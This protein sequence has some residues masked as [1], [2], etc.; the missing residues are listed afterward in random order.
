MCVYGGRTMN[1][2]IM[3]IQQVAEYLQVCDKTIRRLI[4]R[5]ELSDSKIGR[6]W[7]V[8]KNNIDEY[9]L[10]RRNIWGNV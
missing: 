5:K 6:S 3:T 9:L 4:S 7:R 1:N 10:Q 8:K 2:E